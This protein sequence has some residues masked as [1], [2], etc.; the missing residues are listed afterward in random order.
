[1]TRPLLLDKPTTPRVG[2][3]DLF[4]RLMA[5]A[6]QVSVDEARAVLRQQN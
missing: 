6:M 2:L 1:M 5:D 4:V 3:H